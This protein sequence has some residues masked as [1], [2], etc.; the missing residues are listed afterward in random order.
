MYDKFLAKFE[1]IFSDV[2]NFT[3][4]NMESL[5]QDSLKMFKDLQEKLESSDPK[6]QEK[7]LKTTIE[8]KRKLEAQAKSIYE[9]TK[10][11]EKQLDEFMHDP[12]NFSKK[13]WNSMEKAEDRL[14][15][16]QKELKDSI[17][18]P[19]AKRAKKK[20]WMSS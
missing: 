11:N 17:K 3:P 14:E 2:D 10:M 8:L 1:S 13:D 5:V 6:V 20:K 9:T 15:S 18:P 16:Y 12:K 4:E 7:A 19:K